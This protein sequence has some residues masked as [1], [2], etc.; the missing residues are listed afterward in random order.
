M[1]AE[2]A[3]SFDTGIVAS[4]DPSHFLPEWLTQHSDPEQIAAIVLEPILRKAAGTTKNL[5]ILVSEVR[6]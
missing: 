5:F 1:H 2:L 3:T 6:I 4:P